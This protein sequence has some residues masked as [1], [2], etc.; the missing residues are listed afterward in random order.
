[1]LQDILSAGPDEI[2]PR[3]CGRIYLVRGPKIALCIN[4]NVY[5][6]HGNVRRGMRRNFIKSNFGT[7]RNTSARLRRQCYMH[8]AHPK[9]DAAALHPRQC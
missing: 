8:A 3:S 1:V 9:S 4:C 5:R 2:T 7:E 6:S